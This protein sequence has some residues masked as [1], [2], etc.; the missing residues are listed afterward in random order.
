[1][2]IDQAASPTSDADPLRGERPI[3]S[4]QSRASDAVAAVDEL[5]DAV[6]GSDL[7]LLL[8]FCT[9]RTDLDALADALGR[10]FVGTTV[11]GCTT[12]GEIGPGGYQDGSVVAVGLSAAH[13]SAAAE[14]I[15]D[16]DSFDEARSREL[17]AELLDRAGGLPEQT[18]SLLMV[19][20]LSVR[21]E[22]IARQC[23]RALGDVSLVG[24]SA[25][26]DQAFVATHVLHDGCFRPGAVWVVI[27]TELPF[28]IFRSSHFVGDSEPL[29]VTEADADHRILREINGF[30]AA[31]EY[32]RVLGVAVDDLDSALFA[33][34][35]LVVK[36]GGNDYVRSIR[37]V[38]DDDSLTLY[39]AIERGVVL[40][41]ARGLDLVG[42][43]RELFDDVR[44]SIGDPLLTVGFD[45]IHCKVEAE[46]LD[47]KKAI[48]SLFLANNVVGFS[49]YGEQFVGTHVNQT[50]SGIAIGS[51]RR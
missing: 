37:N 35:P 36:V 16:L 17:A 30:P 48:E 40:R 31:V 39:C 42:V 18:V 34:A 22:R 5:Y 10:R 33:S 41:V 27:S 11:V 49:S 9:S 15:A 3:R 21:E 4:A 20:G 2:H 28:T 26:D 43:R 44:R 51:P 12:A 50:L 8:V 1:M 14:H 6:A 19:D 25:G 32:A 45:C 13:F 24:G 38:N 46:N 7:A 29:V 47:G 23:Q